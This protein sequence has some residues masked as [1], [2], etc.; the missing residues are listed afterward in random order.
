MPSSHFAYGDVQTQ[1]RARNIRLLADA[2]TAMDT[3]EFT[4]LY[5]PQ[6]RLSDHQ[7]IVSPSLK[8][9]PLQTRGLRAN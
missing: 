7:I 3:N 5:Q 6:Y 8:I 9:G 4:L 2:P 1:D